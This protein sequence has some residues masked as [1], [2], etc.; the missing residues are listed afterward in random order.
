MVA[1][2]CGASECPR[3]GVGIGDTNLGAGILDSRGTIL[4]TGRREAPSG[5]P[6]NTEGAIVDVVRE[7]PAPHAVRTVRIRPAGFVGADRSSVRSELD[8]AGQSEP[9]Q[10][11]RNGRQQLAV[12]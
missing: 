2:T 7:D 8:Q 4:T 3:L 1:D 11:A 9:R 10:Q 12:A 6:G 5:H